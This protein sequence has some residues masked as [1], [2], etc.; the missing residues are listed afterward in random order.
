MI[1]ELW[2]QWTGQ[3]SL[4]GEFKAGERWVSKNKVDFEL[5]DTGPVW[6]PVRWGPTAEMGNRG[7][8]GSH[9]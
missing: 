6:I 1:P 3:S 9:F 2:A 8:V 7:D 5:T 4:L